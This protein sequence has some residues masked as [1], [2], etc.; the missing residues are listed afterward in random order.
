M[1]ELNYGSCEKNLFNFITIVMLLA[2]KIEKNT[3]Y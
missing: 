1:Q 3:I 2:E